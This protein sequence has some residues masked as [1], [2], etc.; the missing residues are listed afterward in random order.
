MVHVKCDEIFVNDKE[1]LQHWLLEKKQLS[2]KRISPNES[3]E[4]VQLQLKD[5]S[6]NEIFIGPSSMSQVGLG[7]LG[8]KT[9]EQAVQVF[10][11][12]RATFSHDRKSLNFE[13]DTLTYEMRLSIEHL[14]TKI[15][16]ENVGRAVEIEFGSAKEALDEVDGKDSSDSIYSHIPI[17]INK[18][19]KYFDLREVTDDFVKALNLFIELKA[20]KPIS[21]ESYFRSLTFWMDRQGGLPFRRE[22]NLSLLLPVPPAYDVFFKKCYFSNKDLYCGDVIKPSTQFGHWTSDNDEEGERLNFCMA[23]RGQPFV[24]DWSQKRTRRLI[25]WKDL[26]KDAFDRILEECGWSLNQLSAFTKSFKTCFRFTRCM[27]SFKE[28]QKI[29]S[30]MVPVAMKITRNE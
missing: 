14:P 11:R 27:V 30:M 9:Q 7:Q 19:V 23:Y 21:L 16:S 22:N 18:H 13:F 25:L 15:C 8:C 29:W 17:K 24:Y 1:T 3:E 10:E 4:T 28:S 20:L 26:K 5:E 12:C 2:I 6:G